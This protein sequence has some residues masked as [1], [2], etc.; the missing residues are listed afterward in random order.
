MRNTRP[1]DIRKMIQGLIIL[2][3]L[4]WATQTLVSQWGFGDEVFISPRSNVVLEL[5]SEAAVVGNEIRLN[6]L[7]RCGG[8]NDVMEQTGDLIVARFVSGKASRSIDLDELKAILEGAGVNLAAID[9]SGALRCVVTQNEQ[10][11]QETALTE[12]APTTRPVDAVVATSRSLRDL[13]IS[14]LADRFGLPIDSLQV[15]FSPQDE[16]VLALAESSHQFDV[17]PRK[18]RNLGDISWEVTVSSA[19]GTRQ[20]HTISANV[21]AWQTQVTAVR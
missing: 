20:R 2:T 5:K 14:E 12:I 8:A 15:R 6:Q 3:L 18:Q 17:Q 1:A 9:F 11:P 10:T 7:V 21:R 19:Q 13:L 4:A 16:K